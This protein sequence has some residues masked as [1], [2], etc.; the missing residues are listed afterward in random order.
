[1]QRNLQRPCHRPPMPEHT[2]LGSTSQ[3]LQS[4]RIKDSFSAK[5]VQMKCLHLILW[6]RTHS[7]MSMLKSHTYMDMDVPGSDCSFARRFTGL[8]S[9]SSPSAPPGQIR[10]I[11][12][13]C[14]G[15]ANTSES[16]CSWGCLT[17]SCGGIY[18]FEVEGDA[19]ALGARASPEGVEL[20]LRWRRLRHGP[21]SGDRLIGMKSN[22]RRGGRDQQLTWRCYSYRWSAA[23][24]SYVGWTA[25]G[26]HDLRRTVMS[27]DRG[28][29]ISV[30]LVWTSPASRTKCSAA[31]VWE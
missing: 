18:T 21:R 7:V 9:Y 6:R 10:Q 12:S 30:F 19:D 3:I 13:E 20:Q 14:S 22:Q 4:T 11:V 27:I 17:E 24:L 15:S 1:L 8:Y 28:Q 25:A 23:Y 29:R 5:Q 2:W 31:G 26:R 16:S